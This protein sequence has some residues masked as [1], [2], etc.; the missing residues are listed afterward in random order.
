M[1]YYTAMDVFR[2]ES[3]KNALIYDV[4][5]VL[6]ATIFIALSA[7]IRC[8]CAFQPGA[9]NRTDSGRASDR[10]NARKPKRCNGSNYIPFGRFAWVTRLR[11]G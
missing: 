4:V 2:P 3:K 11:A 1:R 5:L 9:Y 7:Q 6:G 8:T 10:C